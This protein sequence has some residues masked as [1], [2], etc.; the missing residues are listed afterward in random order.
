M[1]FL[2]RFTAIVAHKLYPKHSLDRNA[3]ILAIEIVNAEYEKLK[4]KPFG[5]YSALRVQ[6]VSFP[7]D[8]GVGI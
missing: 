1:T 6:S 7:C 5:N 4:A 2:G 8:L 3:Q